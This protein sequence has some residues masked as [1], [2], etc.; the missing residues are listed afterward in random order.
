M[1]MES[2]LRGVSSGQPQLF[3]EIAR[4]HDLRALPEHV[5]FVINRHTAQQTTCL[6]MKGSNNLRSMSV[7]A[8]DET[9][10]AKGWVWV[11]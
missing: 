6:S 7:T 5:N 9:N 2:Q 11:T 4:S 1:E 10:D 8:D 3:A